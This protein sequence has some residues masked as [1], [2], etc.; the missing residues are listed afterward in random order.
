MVTDENTVFLG[1]HC[2]IQCYTNDDQAHLLDPVL[3]C[4]RS[5]QDEEGNLDDWSSH[6]DVGLLAAARRHFYLYTRTKVL[7]DGVGRTV[8][9]QLAILVH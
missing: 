3:P 8:L 7:G 4:T 9:A 1:L 6:H 2:L 5:I